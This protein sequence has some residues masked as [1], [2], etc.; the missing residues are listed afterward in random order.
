VAL[1]LNPPL[2]D[3]APDPACERAARDAVA[4][5]EGLGHSV[6]EIEPPWTQPGLLADFT[7]AFGPLSALTVWFGGRLAG[8]EPTAEDVEPLTWEMWELARSHDTLDLLTAEAK[9]ERVAR[10]IVAF[11]APY[12]VVVTPTLARP[13][14][15][16]GEIHGRGPDPMGHYRRS[17]AFTPY[18]A[19]CNVT[20]LPAIS[21]PLY[22]DGGIPIGVQLIGRPVSEATLLAVS[23]QLEAAVPWIERAPSGLVG[24][25]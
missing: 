7:R 19:I 5:L 14:V 10:E 18:T 9:L 25:L 24:D 13:P 20:G 1:A 11:L 16:I 22:E 4:L 15:P 17:G 23:A 6:Q 3:V 12:D 2:E 8:R 21:L